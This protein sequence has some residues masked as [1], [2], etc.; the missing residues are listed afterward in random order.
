MTLSALA[1]ILVA[2]CLHAGWNLLA[3]Q[4]GGGAVFVWLF[5]ACSSLIYAPFA[6]GLALLHPPAMGPVAWACVAGSACIHLGYFL[7]LQRGYRVGDLTLVYPM[8]RGIGPLL[9]T[10]A[11]IMLLGERPGGI[12][13]AG[14]GLIIV[15]VFVL[16]GGPGGMRRGVPAAAVGYGVLTGMFIA[17]YTVLDKYAVSA[18]LI[19]PLLYDWL[20][21][22]GRM[23]LLTPYALSKRDVVSHQWRHNR[24]AIFGIAV[25]SP[26]AYILVLTAMV[27]TPV[28]YVAPAREVSI[29]IAAVLGVRVLSEPLSL[30]R[31]LAAVGMVLGIIALAIG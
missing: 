26:L 3:K 28:S 6:L 18:L 30:P 19:P 4:A 2:A 14:A 1:L 27:F 22:L 29:L 8:A 12:A 5:A 20:G 23:L 10:C 21:N 17:T 13:L 9:A 11:A 25:M 24:R 7:S 16:A 15:S 31:V